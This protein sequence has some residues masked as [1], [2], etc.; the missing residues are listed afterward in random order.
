MLGD[1]IYGTSTP[2]DYEIKFERPYRALLDAGVMFHAAIGNH[3]PSSQIYYGKFNM[4]GRRAYVSRVGAARGRSWRRRSL[5]RARQPVT[6]SGATRMAAPGAGGIRHRVEDLFLP[7]SSVYLQPLSRCRA[8]A[9]RLALEPIL[10]AGDVDV[11]LAGHEHLYERIQPRRES[12]ISRPARPGSLRRGDLM[13]STVSGK[14]FDQDYSFMLMEVS[15]R[16]VLVDHAD[17][18]HG[19]R[20]GDLAARDVEFSR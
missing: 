19:R 18:P 7:S 12:A 20:R 14:G 5:F 3:D 11:V 15:G 10:V 8:R 1:N 2:H 4:N 9:L 17:R 13:S 16:A 6:R